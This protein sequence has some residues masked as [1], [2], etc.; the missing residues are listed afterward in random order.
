MD[1]YAKSKTPLEA[2]DRR[3]TPPDV[4]GR[5]Q[6]VANI[7]F[8]WDVCA[9][10]HTAKVPGGRHWTKED[11]SLSI[12]WHHELT[13]D[14]P[15]GYMPAVWMNPPYS[16]PTIWCDKASLEASKGMFV[17][18][19]LPDDRSV[20]WYRRFVDNVAPDVWVP[21]R[22]ISFHDENGEPQNGNPKG[23]VFILW[24]PWRTRH[25]QYHRF[26]IDGAKRPPLG[27]SFKSKRRVRKG[28]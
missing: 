11:D 4:F 14:A 28:K 27:L 18:G 25:T 22:R 21:D 19:L 12:D 24:T 1:A 7:T 5:I 10:D 6:H 20:E 16:D 9:Q 17:M 13:K 15:P 3:A 23:S 2:R 26:T 8:V